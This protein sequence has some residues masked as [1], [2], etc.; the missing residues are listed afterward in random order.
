MIMMPDGER[1][2]RIPYRRT[3]RSG[4]KL[5]AITL[6]LWQNF[7]DDRPLMNSRAMLRRAFELGITHF[8]LANNYGP[9]YGSA[10]INFGRIFS[11]DFAAYRDEIV[12]STKA[13]YDMWD[14][15]Y[16]EWGSRKY[17]L[18][19][20]EQSLTRMGLDNVHIFYS[21]RFGPAT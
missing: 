15:P 1:Y 6:G 16:G 10:E 19:S 13:G 21:H 18:A 12:V 9:P 7:G 3:G 20:L 4:L 11:E 17:V 5:P 8:D 14:G 2:A